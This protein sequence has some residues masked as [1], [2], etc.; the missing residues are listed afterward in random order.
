M[1]D[2]ADAAEQTIE[3]ELAAHLSAIKERIGPQL[4]P[5]GVCHNCEADLEPGKLFCAPVGTG[6]SECQTDY[7]YRTRRVGR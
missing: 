7:E 2:I 5:I 1:P 3:L 6:L 4:V